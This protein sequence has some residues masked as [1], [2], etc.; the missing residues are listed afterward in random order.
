MKK[1]EILLSL[2][3]LPIALLVAGCQDFDYGLTPAKVSEEVVDNAYRVF[4]VNYNE[5]QDWNTVNSGSVVVTADADL[6]NIAKVQILTGS[7]FGAG[8][9]N[10][11]TILNETKANNGETVTLSYDAPA[12]L[13]RLY[14]ACVSTDGQYYIKGFDVGQESVS[15]EDGQE[16]RATTYA[17]SVDELPKN[18][19]IG[20]IEASFSNQRNWAGWAND[21]L[22]QLADAD[23]QIQ[24]IVLNDYSADY[25]QDLREILFSYLP[26]KE[27]NIEKIKESKYYNENCYAITTGSD[28]IVVAP[29]YKNDGTSQEVNNSHLY[30]Y[31]F[32]DS[33]IAGMSEEEQVQFFKNRPKFKAIPIFRSVREKYQ[34]TGMVNDVIKKNLG[35]TLIYWGDET[36][37]KGTVGSYQFPK[38]YKIG[39]M[40]RGGAGSSKDGKKCGEMYCDGRLNAEIN[41]Y[42]DYASG[43]LEATDSRMAWIGANKRNYLCCETGAD[44]DINDVVFEVEGGIVPFSEYGNMFGQIYTFCF[45]DREIGDYD[46][47]DVVIK[48]VR[49]DRTRVLYSLEACG[50]TDELYLRNINGK[51]L[52]ERREIH[53]IFNTTSLV[54]V[55]GNTR[56]KPVQEII[57]VDP[58]FT[59]QDMEKQVYIYNASAGR[60]VRLSEK[61][62]DPHALMIADDFQYPSEGICIKNAYPAFLLWM[63][64]RAQ[65]LDWYLSPDDES[66]YHTA[67]EVEKEEEE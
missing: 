21:Y 61:G 37:V 23:E 59:F 60:A 41:R 56:I 65:S 28:P 49:I 46:M 11:A 26:N 22:Y 36:P 51:V 54:N 25:I 31:Y 45:E 52:N 5:G 7:P 63:V 44:R 17:Y 47:N 35:Y 15:F 39:F 14:A 27:S 32:K 50:G 67:F 53:S 19:V 20:R 1:N 48:A 62:D 43:K 34:S 6:D 12:R 2:S 24:G 58:S 55:S 57:S 64:D 33:D 18:P 42:G 40:I 4:G 8:N 10:G 13:T 16:T 3:A 30:Y 9:T 29:I 38:G 66:I